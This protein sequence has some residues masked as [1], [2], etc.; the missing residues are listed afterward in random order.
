MQGPVATLLE[1]FEV[2]YIGDPDPTTK[3]LFPAYLQ[4]TYA[5]NEDL[6]VT[7]TEPVW[8]ATRLEV[9]VR[10]YEKM[11]EVAP[12]YWPTRMHHYRDADLIV[13][14]TDAERAVLRDVLGIPTV[15]WLPQAFFDWETAL[16]CRTPLDMSLDPDAFRYQHS[17]RPRP[18]GY[19]RTSSAYHLPYDR[20]VYQ[21]LLRRTSR[22][23]T[24][25]E[26]VY[27]AVN[28]NTFYFSFTR[29]ISLTALKH[30]LTA[31]TPY[32]NMGL[33]PGAGR[34]TKPWAKRL[35]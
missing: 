5:F 16:L 21:A 30:S 14:G 15:Y 27:L 23:Y 8:C 22:Y 4:G 26:L 28:S 34:R 31:L 1:R 11:T 25:D 24:F 29:P 18:V 7:F 6:A 9:A 3:F 33:N 2:N 32:S 13:Y 19:E 10:C 35:L 20:T 17:T 12:E